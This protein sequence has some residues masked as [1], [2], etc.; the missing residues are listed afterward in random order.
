MRQKGANAPFFYIALTKRSRNSVPGM[1]KHCCM[2]DTSALAFAKRAHRSA[3]ND[4]RGN[5]VANHLLHREGV[6]LMHHFLTQ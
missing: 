2:I 5:T 6:A 1:D 4:C 3:R